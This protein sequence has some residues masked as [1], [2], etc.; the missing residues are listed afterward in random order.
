MTKV[1]CA[2]LILNDGSVNIFVQ[3]TRDVTNF[4]V[5][6]YYFHLL[7][8]F[9]SKEEAL[10]ILNVENYLNQDLLKR[11]K[12]NRMLNWSVIV[13]VQMLLRHDVLDANKENLGRS[14]TGSS[15]RLIIKI[16]NTHS[17]W[18]YRTHFWFDENSWVS[19]TESKLIES[20]PKM[21]WPSV[22]ERTNV[23]LCALINLLHIYNGKIENG[24]K[25]DE[26]R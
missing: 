11:V 7:F 20:I 13:V 23:S 2:I 17:N 16:K 3:S 5:L 12:S 6:V 22:C 15:D 25:K 8:K 10:H 24:N 18:S 26:V 21:Q 1:H 19:Q 9:N 4:S 14:N